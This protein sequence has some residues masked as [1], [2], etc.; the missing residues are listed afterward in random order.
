[1]D[2][3]LEQSHNVLDGLMFQN[4]KQFHSQT[5]NVKPD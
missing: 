1:M 5:I 4:L 3:S 2:Y